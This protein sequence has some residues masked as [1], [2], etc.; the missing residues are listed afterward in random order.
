MGFCMNG[1]KWYISVRKAEAGYMVTEPLGWAHSYTT[2]P[3][4]HPAISL[5]KLQTRGCG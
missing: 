1:F 2:S 5:F 3:S 4:L